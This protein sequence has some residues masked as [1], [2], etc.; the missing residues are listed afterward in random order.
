MKITEDIVKA[1]HACIADGYDS[2]A[3]FA[4]RVNVSANTLSKYMRRETEVMQKDTW[5]K[6]QPLLTAYL[7]KDGDKVK[8]EIEMTADQKI[9]LDAFDSLPPDV[10]SQKLMEII[11]LAK[12]HLAAVEAEKNG[13]GA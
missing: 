1:L 9:L 8:Y 6:L 7:P 2:V 4:S 10:Q 3:D 11:Q 12:R 13:A 5:L